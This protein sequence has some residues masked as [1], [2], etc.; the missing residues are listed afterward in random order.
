MYS[1]SYNEKSACWIAK[2]KVD[3]AWKTK[4]IP[5]IYQ[6]HNKNDAEKWLIGW[7]ANPAPKHQVVLAKYRLVDVAERWLE[8]RRNSIST[9]PHYYNGLELSLKNWILDNPNFKHYSIQNLDLEKDFSVDVIRRWIQSLSGAASS[10]L[11]HINALRCLFND[12][13]AEN[14]LDENMMNPFDR[15]AVK[16]MIGELKSITAN[17]NIETFDLEFGQALVSG[18]HSKITLY[19]RVRYLLAMTTGMR[20]NEIQGL[21]W[22]HID[23]EHNVIRVEQQLMKSGGG[24]ALSYE[25]LLAKG[26]NKFEIMKRN[27]AIVGLPKRNSVRVIP[28]HSE[29]RKALQQWWETGWKH[30]VGKSPTLAHPVFPKGRRE[31]NHGGAAGDFVRGD[32]RASTTFARD[33]QRLGLVDSHTFHACRRS[34]AT[35]M[36]AAGV[37]S[38]TIGQLL[39]H[40]KGKTVALK[41]YVRV[42]M[43]AYVEAVEK[44]N[45][46]WK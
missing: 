31:V 23:W 16:K 25:Q 32:A 41:H 2:V 20:V 11:T 15:P 35:W 45:L 17:R 21:Q 40:G 4:Y 33:C 1:M 14:I 9:K 18:K 13:I 34:W 19:R 7:I 28:L 39:G 44:V 22:K 24:E 38:E 42:Q 3:G 5:K 10:R 43:D 37:S 36:Y 26:F 46:V 6:R 30:H 8:L 27:V 29:L 12:L